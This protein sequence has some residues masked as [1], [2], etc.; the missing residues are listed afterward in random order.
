[1]SILNKFT[2]SLSLATITAFAVIGT[3]LPSVQVEA[4]NGT[5]I[6]QNNSTTTGTYGQDIVNL[7]YCWGNQQVFS[8]DI[9]PVGDWS[10]NV[11]DASLIPA[12]PCFNI[13]TETPQYPILDQINFSIAENSVT[14][15]SIDG[16]AIALSEWSE[17]MGNSIISSEPL[18]PTFNPEGNTGFLLSAL[19]PENDSF[20]EYD[21]A[22]I[23]G[24]LYTGTPFYGNS[25]D[26]EEYF[27]DLEPGT[28]NIS[29]PSF[30]SYVCNTEQGFEL[31]VAMGEIIPV[32]GV[33]TTNPFDVDGI[34][35]TAG[36]PVLTTQEEVMPIQ[37]EAENV[38]PIMMT[39]VRTGGSDF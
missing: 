19:N 12:D 13:P 37:N 33:I 24:V 4:A 5:L 11:V 34:I 2:K 15:I 22:C 7:A 21:V 16:T 28:Y 26:I 38:S 17:I 8:G 3:I 14:T 27:Y 10:F 18:S 35:A 25:L 29:F 6:I 39:T 23:D 9:L 1:M 30:P 36:E 31:T 20:F 32:S